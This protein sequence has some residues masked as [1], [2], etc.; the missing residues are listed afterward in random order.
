MTAR[1]V[2]SREFDCSTSNPFC[3]P[4]EPDSFIVDIV[5]SIAVSITVDTGIEVPCVP[6]IRH[7]VK[8]ICGQIRRQDNQISFNGILVTGHGV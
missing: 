8:R 1:F 3:L 2:P 7:V 4:L 6:H 5:G